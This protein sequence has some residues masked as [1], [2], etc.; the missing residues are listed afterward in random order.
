MVQSNEHIVLFIQFDKQNPDIMEIHLT[1][2]ELNYDVTYWSHCSSLMNNDDF[3]FNSRHLFDSRCL[4]FC[5][6]INNRC[7]P[8]C[9][10]D[11]LFSDKNIYE[12][13]YGLI[14]KL[15]IKKSDSLDK[16]DDFEAKIF[17]FEKNISFKEIFD[18]ANCYR[19]VYMGFFSNDY[20]KEYGNKNV[21]FG[22]ASF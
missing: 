22:N 7:N 17:H 14:Y 19:K 3:N 18:Y 21:C 2:N 5:C 12:H 11:W 13:N 15:S 1:K 6:K 4:N 20:S 16:C 9:Y 8:Y 10:L